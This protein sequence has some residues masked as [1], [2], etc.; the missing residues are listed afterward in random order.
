[1][2]VGKY[3]V[4]E[5]HLSQLSDLGLMNNKHIFFQIRRPISKSPQF[6]HDILLSGLWHELF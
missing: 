3:C 2:G 1:M 5:I 4:Q 6:D